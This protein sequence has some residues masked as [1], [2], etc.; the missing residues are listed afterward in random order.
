MNIQE[1]EQLTR[2]L[3]ELALARAN[4]KDSEAENLIRE[5]CG[6][7]PDAYYLLVQRCLL[8]DQAVQHS[9]AENAR[10]QSELENACG[11][12]NFLNANAWGNSN[13]RS[14]SPPVVGYAPPVQA[15]PVPVQAPAANTPWGSGMLGA[16]ATTAAGVVA[17]SFLFQG[18]EHL[19]GHH[20]GGSGF[21]GGEHS[22]LVSDTSSDSVTANAWDDAS[23]GN[24]A[25]ELDSLI[26]SDD[27]LGS[28]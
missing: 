13:I 27:E 22:P 4:A 26:P 5:A 10:L 28:V 9:Q 20:A 6:R 23:S 17:G 8:L 16:V 1:R 19:M 7:Q 3:Q 14:T 12:S 24:S 2:F 18:I 11:G 25:N 15:A 21:M